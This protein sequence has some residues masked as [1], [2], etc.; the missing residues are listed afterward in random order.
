[1]AGIRVKVSADGKTTRYEARI[2]RAGYP[3]I[4]KTYETE[5]EA[6][7]WAR[8]IELRYDRGSTSIGSPGKATVESVISQ[9]LREHEDAPTSEIARLN[10]VKEFLG[11]FRITSIHGRNIKEWMK[12]ASGAEIPHAAKRKKAS[13][14]Y[15]GDTKR[16]YAPSTIRKWFFSLKKVLEWH[17]RE[18]RYE[19]D[20][21][22]FK[23]YQIPKAWSN[24]SER[25]LEIGEEKRILDACIDFTVRNKQG[26]A[27][28]TQ[29]RAHGEFYAALVSF[30]LETAARAQEML[31]AEWGEFDI[32][33]RTWVIPAEHAKTK[34]SRKVPLSKNARDILIEL[35]EKKSATDN[36]VFHEIPLSS[37]KVALKRILKDAGI[38]DP[39]FG[40]HVFRHECISRWVTT[41]PNLTLTQCMSISGHTDQR[42]F[43]RYANLRPSEIAPLLD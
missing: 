17:A 32:T 30:A 33:G 2:H 24:E 19:L 7:A 16:T 4:S 26:K 9:Y 1:M 34:K 3:P 27:A 36:R 14:L 39:G 38:T 23:G 42:T 43:L 37:N 22:L 35:K 40:Y 5:K 11:Q 18:H 20:E 41:K 10:R 6:K 12:Q 15:A 31:L 25:R 29:S 21:H 28:G 13:P 8:A